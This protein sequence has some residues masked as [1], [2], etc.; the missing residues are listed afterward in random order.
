MTNATLLQTQVTPNDCGIRRG[1]GYSLRAPCLYSGPRRWLSRCLCLMR[2]GRWPDPLPSSCSLR[3]WCLLF[4]GGCEDS[5][6]R[7]EQSADECSVLP[8][9]PGGVPSPSGEYP[10]SPR[11]LLLLRTHDVMAYQA[12]SS[13]ALLREVLKAGPLCRQRILDPKKISPMELNS[14]CP[15]HGT[16]LIQYRVAVVM[17]R[18]SSKARSLPTRI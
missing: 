9:H 6:S 17:P 3:W 4:A 18:C 16:S 14:T 10:F 15:E 5:Q 11:R 7:A 12:A 1:N 13:T 8:P 2:R